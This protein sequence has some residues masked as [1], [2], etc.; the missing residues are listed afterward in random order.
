M[1]ATAS[2]NIS[3]YE[4]RANMPDRIGEIADTFWDYTGRPLVNDTRIRAAAKLLDMSNTFE[5]YKINH[6]ALYN[7][8]DITPELQNLSEQWFIYVAGMERLGKDLAKRRGA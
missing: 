2:K 6:Q 1:T 8:D 7:A 3:Y 4:Q 5:E